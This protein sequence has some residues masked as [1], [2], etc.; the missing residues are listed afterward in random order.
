MGMGS[1][2]YTFY[3]M[4]DARRAR[5][6]PSLRRLLKRF[7]DEVRSYGYTACLSPN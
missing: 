4:P 1:L 6:S 5:P 3:E 2:P 7:A